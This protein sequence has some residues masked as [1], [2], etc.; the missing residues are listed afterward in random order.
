[1][2]SIPYLSPR[3]YKIWQRVVDREMDEQYKEIA[4]V[5]GKNKRV[6]E[7]GCGPALLFSYLPDGCSYV[8]W[9][10]NKKFVEYARR[11]GINVYQRDIFD[12]KK[13]PQSDVIVVC[14]LLHHIFPRD[15]LFIEEARKRTKKLI[16]VEPYKTSRF[17]FLPY[18]ILYF[19]DRIIG[20]DDGI[21]CFYH[22]KEWKFEK[23][24][25]LKEYFQKLGASKTYKI[26]GIE[27]V[28]VI[29]NKK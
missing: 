11:K 9:D 5:V 17:S 22:R 26:R 6:F 4:R 28:L 18:P 15:K 3:I 23:A 21:N 2:S 20:D 29:F 8:G 10:L 7:P 24:G 25:Y 27:K 19:Y 14:D 16:V 12:F 13:Y 1:M